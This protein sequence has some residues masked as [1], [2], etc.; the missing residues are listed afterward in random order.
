MR[1]T[2]ASAVASITTSPPPLAKITQSPSLPG[3]ASFPKRPSPETTNAKTLKPSGTGCAT[4]PPFPSEKC[5][6]RIGVRVSM[7][8]SF[9]SDSPAI[10][11][12][13]TFPSALAPTGMRAAGISWYR[14]RMRLSFFGRFTQSWKPCMRPPVF[15][16]SGSGISE[17]TTPSPA[18]IHWTSPGVSAP[19]CPRES[20][21]RIAPARRYVTVSKPRCGWSGAPTA[22]PGE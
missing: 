12:T 16:N 6:Y 22:L 2:S 21:W 14:G 17:W 10:T 7:T 4:R 13:T 9:P 15:W 5:R 3:V 20:R 8:A 18:V 11:R 1:R 19:A